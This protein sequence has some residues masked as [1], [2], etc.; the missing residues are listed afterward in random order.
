MA[1]KFRWTS[2]ALLDLVS[3][4]EYIGQDNPKAAIDLTKKIVLTIVEQLSSFQNI[5][6]AGRVLGTRE[7]IVSN[8][9]YIAVYWVKEGTVEILRVLHSSLKWPDNF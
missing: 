7:L 6:K 1:N 4:K 5:G 9:P 3:I 8:T 2:K